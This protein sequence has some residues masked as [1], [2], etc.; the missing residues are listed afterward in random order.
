LLERKALEFENEIQKILYFDSIPFLLQNQNKNDYHLEKIKNFYNKYHE[1]ITNISIIDNQQQALSVFMDKDKNFIID[2]YPP[3]YQKQLETKEKIKY[4]NDEWHFITVVFKGKDAIANIIV[5]LEYEK[6]IQTNLATINKYYNFDKNTWQLVINDSSKIIYKSIADSVLKITAQE[7]IQKSIASEKENW[8]QHKTILEKG[9]IKTMSY[10][11]PFRLVRRNFALIF[12]MDIGSIRNP[13]ILK[14]AVNSL[15]III[16]STIIFVLIYRI[17]SEKESQDRKTRE[18]ELN[19]HRIFDSIPIGVMILTFDKTIRFINRTATEMLY[20]KDETNIIGRNIADMIIPKYFSDKIKS[21]AAYDTGHFY[22]FDK[23]GTEITI[24]KK[25]I[26]FKLNTEDLFIEAFIDVSP[27]EKS[28]KLEAAANLAKSDFLAKMSHEI[29]TPMNG[30]VGMADALMQQNLT[31]EQKEYAEIIK[32]SSDLL[33]TIINDILDFS[34]VE[35]GKMMLEEIPFKVSDEVTLICELFR[36]IAEKK[37]IKLISH[38][39]SNVPDNIIGDPFR[40]RQVISNLMSNALKFTHEGEVVISVELMEE[41]S[42]HLTLL[43]VVED[44]GIGIPQDKLESIFA[45]Y[46]QAEGSISRKYGGSGLGTTISKQLVELMGGEIWVESPSTI[47]TNKEFPGSRFCF[48]IEAFSNEKL[49]KSYD[50]SKITEYSQISALIITSNIDEPQPI[51]SFLDNFGIAFEKYH[52]DP[53]TPELL[54]NKLLIEY[55]KYQIVILNDSIEYN[56]FALAKMLFEKGITY[57][58]LFIMISSNDISG[59]FIRSKRLGI[60]YYLIIPYESSEVFDLIQNSFDAISPDAKIPAKMSKIRK[61]INILVAE[62]NMINQKV[63]KTIFKNLG[64]EIIFA[65]NGVEAVDMTIQYNYD[66]IFMD[67]MMPE[68]DGVQATKDLRKQGYKGP[69]I[70]MTANATKEGK[71]KAI[72]F[73][74][75]GYITKPTKIEEIKK[76]LIKYFSEPV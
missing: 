22:V 60:D 33:L 11:A 32:K 76:V 70:A 38:I 16:L 74:M 63:A 17:V 29:R 35:A 34:K 9:S 14:A 54:I 10:T 57:R 3:H 37:E 25:D 18:D 53:Q 66:I 2:F 8:F 44:T 47:S 56:G 73:G 41:Y 40:L 46:I 75:D 19:L 23:E 6:F 58:H 49:Q 59:N 30:I 1:F 42:G 55:E 62:D 64:F 43:F 28:R 71:N 21:D 7:Q 15:I 31:M 5:T 20:G 45:S 52:L 67:M 72:S 39:A 48:T 65:N 69:I 26:P 4:I 24:Y 13:L 61:N 51:Y 36:P 68:K 50:F 12:S 27:I